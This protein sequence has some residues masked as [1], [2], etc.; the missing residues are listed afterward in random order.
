M[1]GPS[2]EAVDSREPQDLQGLAALQGS[3]A[4]NARSIGAADRLSWL[5]WNF[6]F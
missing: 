3:L 5:P 6:D 2:R 1:A 4:R